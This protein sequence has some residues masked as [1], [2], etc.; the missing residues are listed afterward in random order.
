MLIHQRNLYAP[1]SR[2]CTGRR[3]AQSRE[4]VNK[5]KNF[6]VLCQLDA[7]NKILVFILKDILLRTVYV[8]TMRCLLIAGLPFIMGAVIVQSV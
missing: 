4:P 5:G 6:P 3:E 7:G 8:C 2:Q 1:R